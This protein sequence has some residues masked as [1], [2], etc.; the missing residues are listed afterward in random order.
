MT[1]PHRAAEILYGPGHAELRVAE[2]L[3]STGQWEA[4]IARV[5]RV[6]SQYPESFIGHR[7]LAFLLVRRQHYE[8]ALE[9]ARRI[10]SRRPRDVRTWLLLGSSL[11]GLGRLEEADEA[12]AEAIRIDPRDIEALLSRASFLLAID[13]PAEVGGLVRSALEVD[14]GC[15]RAHVCAAEAAIQDEKFER[16]LSAANAALVLN[17]ESVDGHACGAFA[18]LRLGRISHA[19]RHAREATRIDPQ[20]ERAARIREVVDLSTRLLAIPAT[21]YRSR[22]HRDAR[23]PWFLIALFVAAIPLLMF[24]TSFAHPVLVPVASFFVFVE[25]LRWIDSTGRI[26]QWLSPR[27]HRSSMP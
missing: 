17:P 2:H 10:L 1:T 18:A 24:L 27:R 6:L 19:R 23:T 26:G 3:A 14:P 8:E 4:A 20:D 25:Y 12:Y 22:L 16:A 7:F 9:E 21:L 5:G 13:R 11:H 15:E